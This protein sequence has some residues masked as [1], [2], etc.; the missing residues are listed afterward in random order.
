MVC[1]WC[2]DGKADEGIL[3]I[4]SSTWGR[5]WNLFSLNS[6]QWLGK[7]KLEHKGWRYRPYGADGRLLGCKLVLLWEKTENEYVPD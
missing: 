2:V 4:G 1:T 5:V 7:E 3:R 6:G